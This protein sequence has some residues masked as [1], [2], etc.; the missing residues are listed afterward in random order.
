MEWI[1][2]KNQKPEKH[3]DYLVLVTWND[4]STLIDIEHYT[5]KYGFANFEGNVT[6]WMPL[7]SQPEKINE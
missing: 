6:Y 7:P 5:K 3:G 4:G 2:Y 1:T